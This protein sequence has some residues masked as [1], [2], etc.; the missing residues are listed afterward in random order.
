[1]FIV[2][3]YSSTRYESSLFEPF[4]TND[5]S[6]AIAVGAQWLI[7]FVAEQCGEDVEP[8]D[9]VVLDIEDN[10]EP[11][12]TFDGELVSLTDGKVSVGELRKV[13]LDSETMFLSAWTRDY[14]NYN[15]SVEIH[16]V[17][18]PKD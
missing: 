6:K 4:A 3:A 2:T 7:N 12:G 9:D 5:K 1:M 10:I 11:C 13:L 14:A 16:E 15:I 18:V 17:D 8:A